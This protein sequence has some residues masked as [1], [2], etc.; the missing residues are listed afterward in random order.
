[1]LR[2][3]GDLGKRVKLKPEHEADL[4]LACEKC[5]ISLDQCE[6]LIDK[7]SAIQNDSSHPSKLRRAWQRVKLDPDDVRHLRDQLSSQLHQLNTIQLAID[8]DLVCVVHERVEDLQQSEIQ[9]KRAQVSGWY[10]PASFAEQQTDL[11]SRRHPATGTWFLDHPQ[12]CHWRDNVGSTLLCPG[13]PGVGK[14]L[15]VAMV[16]DDLFTRFESQNDVLVVY[17]YCNFKRQS[18][19][20]LNHCLAALVRQLFQEQ[21]RLPRRVEDLYLRHRD[22]GTRPSTD[23]LKSVLHSLV[24][25]YQRTFVVIDALDECGDAYD[26]LS[27]ELFMLQGRDGSNVSILATTR[28]IPR[29]TNRFSTCPQLEIRAN[30]DDIERYL[31]SNMST[32]SSFVLRDPGLQNTIKRQIIDAADGM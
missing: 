28:H 24:C 22:R 25:D 20:T 9:W 6:K 27:D 17:L 19:Q 23:E 12:Y 1:M 32:L 30:N 8:S 18:V 29:I 2:G 16:V 5:Q 10:S 13:N 21:A 31:D 7:H 26:Q 14:S 4:R 11:L 3:I 15:M